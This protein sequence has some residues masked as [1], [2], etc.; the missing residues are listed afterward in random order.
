[1]EALAERQPPRRVPGWVRFVAIYVAGALT[2]G[3][4]VVL[5]DGS[6]GPAP[7]VPREP[8]LPVQLA[9]AEGDGGEI[10]LS[11]T[12]TAWANGYLA[13]FAAA[14]GRRLDVSVPS[15]SVSPFLATSIVLTSLNRDA[16]AACDE[17][18]PEWLLVAN[19]LEVC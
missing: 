11:S 3:L 7:S 6:G 12:R 14:R 5:S 15:H 1:M 16:L 17:A 10:D 18:V 9:A 8:E 2:M 13:G 19:G 4:I